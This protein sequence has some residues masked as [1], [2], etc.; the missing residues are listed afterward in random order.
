MG[1]L[2]VASFLVGVFAGAAARYTVRRL[3]GGPAVARGWCEGGCAIAFAVVAWCVPPVTA[4]AMWTMLAAMALCWW[5]VCLTATDVCARRLP[6]VLTLPGFACAV[7]YGATTDRLA[8]ALVGAAMLGGTYLV[9]YEGVPG[10]LGAGD[11]KLALGLGAVASLGGGA[12]WL[13]AAALAPLLT[14]VVGAVLV[15]TRRSIAGSR[16]R[17]RATIAHGPAMCVGT[18][19]ALLTAAL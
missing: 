8:P 16:P 3:L 2:S 6:N 12:V 4:D 1:W 7:A 17:R 9:L 18:L 19:V 11:V 5:C 13:T 14:A 15:G 10:A